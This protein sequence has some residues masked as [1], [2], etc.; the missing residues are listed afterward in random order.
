MLLFVFLSSY[1]SPTLLRI[2]GTQEITPKDENIQ[3]QQT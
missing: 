3:Q 2:V 1:L